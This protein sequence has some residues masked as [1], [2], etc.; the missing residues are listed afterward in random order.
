MSYPIA[1]VADEVSITGAYPR[2]LVQL[3]GE[4]GHARAP[5][6]E[7]A[8]LS[9]SALESVEA[10][11]S[12]T[13]YIAVVQAA[14]RMSGDEGLGCALAVRTPPT[15]HG[16]L[17]VAMM[18]AD[19]LGDALAL[20]LR[21]MPLL[22]DK[23][24]LAY[25][26]DDTHAYL[27]PEFQVLNLP[28]PLHRFF[29][30]ALMLGTARSAAWMLGQERLEGE[31]WFDFPE[32]AY[33]AAYAAHLPMV[34]HGM[35][36]TQLCMPVGL[37]QQR[38]PLA[39]VGARTR[40][41]AQC[42]REMALLAAGVVNLSARVREILQASTGHY[43][44]A[45]ETAARLHMSVRTFKRR[46]AEQGTCFRDLLAEAQRLDAI[47]LLRRPQLSLERIAMELGFADPANFTRAFKRWTGRTPSSYRLR[48]PG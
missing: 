18:S 17:G 30:E 8:G 45:E 29:A 40:A 4:R 47:G 44:D 20:G 31:L 22:Q 33:H 3:M 38:L 16:P 27:R 28:L 36:C 9:M 25:W 12:M 35:P 1:T 43:P 32:P 14:M 26:Q 41:L 19:T 37:L 6:L 5:L 24:P 10:R 23:A 7:A 21:Y 15:A 13:Q 34:R 48:E 42:E 39:D 46:L 11:V 2:L